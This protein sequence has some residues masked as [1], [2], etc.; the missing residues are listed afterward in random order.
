[1]PEY[2]GRHVQRYP[3]DPLIH[4]PLFRHGENE[5][6]STEIVKIQSGAK[7]KGG[8]GGGDSPPPTPDFAGHRGSL[9]GKN[10][11]FDMQKCGIWHAKII[12]Q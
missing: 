6:M 4:D 12:I 1:M 11:K 5:Q 2:P 10:V 7:L 8:D 3:V 9:R